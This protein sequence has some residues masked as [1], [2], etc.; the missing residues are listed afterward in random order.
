MHCLYQPLILVAFMDFIYIQRNLRKWGKSSV[1]L[2]I[3][4][5]FYL[6][7]L[8][9]I[10]QDRMISTPARNQIERLA[11]AINDDNF[12]RAQRLETLDA[13]VA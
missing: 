2:P 6:R 1:T 9:P 11:R 12:R 8:A 13:N 3:C 7:N 5:F 4:Y 10:D